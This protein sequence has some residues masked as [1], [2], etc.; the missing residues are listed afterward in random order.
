MKK[1]RDVFFVMLCIGITLLFCFLLDPSEVFNSIYKMIHEYFSLELPFEITM[2]QSFVWVI[3][4]YL[5]IRYIQTNIYIERQY[6]Y[7]EQLENKIAE[8]F[9]T[10]FNRESKN[11]ED[12]YPLVLKLIHI[13]YVWIFPVMSIVI[14]ISKIYFEKIQKINIIPFFFDLTIAIIIILINIFYLIFLHSKAMVERFAKALKK[15]SVSRNIQKLDQ[16]LEDLSTKDRQA[17]AQHIKN[18]IS[19]EVDKILQP[20]N[21]E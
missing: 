8:Q 19:N 14:I 1:K 12:K 15:A 5:F 11:Y 18:C 6:K 7:I 17:L 20:E 3:T 21:I 10:D 2:I 13:I 9:N 16:C 4:L